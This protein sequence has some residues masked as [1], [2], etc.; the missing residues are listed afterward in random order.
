MGSSYV[1]AGATIRTKTDL[2]TA[3]EK[4]LSSLSNLKSAVTSY[5]NSTVNFA[6]TT[7]TTISN[8]QTLFENFKTELSKLQ[9]Q[10]GLPSNS[11]TDTMNMS[12]SNMG[13]SL[14]TYTDTVKFIHTLTVDS[15]ACTKEFYDGIIAVHG[16]SD[17]K[18][19][20][21]TDGTLK[22]PLSW[23]KL[24]TFIKELKKIKEGALS[25]KWETMKTKRTMCNEKES[26]YKAALEESGSGYSEYDLL[27]L[28][29]LGSTPKPDK[30][31]EIRIV[32]GIAVNTLVND[33]GEASMVFEPVYGKTLHMNVPAE[34][35]LFE[36]SFTKYDGY[37]GMAI[38]YYALAIMFEKT[39]IQQMVLVEQ[40][41]QIEK[42]NEAIQYNNKILTALSWLYQ[43]AYTAVTKEQNHDRVHW[44]SSS[45]LQRATGMSFSTLNAYFRGL[46]SEGGTEITL[47]SNGKFHV[48]AAKYN[49]AGLKWEDTTGS[50]EDKIEGG[51]NFSNI[52]VVEQGSLTGISSKQDFIRMHGDM[53]STDAQMMST[54]MQQYMQDANAAV[55]AASQVVKSVGEYYKT[56]VSNIR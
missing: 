9:E 33:A 49:I 47:E 3:T 53:L 38:P 8:I 28:C 51:K 42:I 1:A 40:L 24:G 22:S 5:T 54:K 45:T 30:N 23:A 31:G 10:P 35:A 43:D 17:L 29:L 46:E 48:P 19:L 52:D 27:S 11:I 7:D 55:S 4:S 6:N 37:K 25:T 14:A 18:N 15:N 44:I 34:K 16:S 13:S 36:D 32:T 2:K 41:K 39:C 50:N 21:N 12:I 20:Y 56:I 26:A